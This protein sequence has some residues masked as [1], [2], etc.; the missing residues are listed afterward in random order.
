MPRPEPEFVIDASARNADGGLR[1]E[2]RQRVG[3]V[4]RGRGFILLPSDTAYS[5]AAVLFDVAVRRRINAL[6]NRGDE[7]ISLAFGSAMGADRWI[8]PNPGVKQLIARYCPGPITIVCRTPPRGI[9]RQLLNQAIAS[10]NRTIGIRVPNSQ[11]E[12]DVASVTPYPVTT[13][14]IRENGSVVT[15]LAISRRLVM[16]GLERAGFPRWGVIE[17]TDAMTY[18]QHSTVV[19]I[20]ADGSGIRILRPGHIAESEIRETLRITDTDTSGETR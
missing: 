4:L 18:A 13:V 7:P 6:L 2:D 14:A 8:A 1:N 11:V 20:T 12:R 3:D 10:E 9:P 15:S 17:G 19:E 16:E 5:V